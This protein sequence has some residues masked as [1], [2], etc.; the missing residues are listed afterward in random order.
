MNRRIDPA[1]G[2][3]GSLPTRRPLTTVLPLLVREARGNRLLPRDVRRAGAIRPRKGTGKLQATASGG[4]CTVCA[5]DLGS[6]QPFRGFRSTAFRVRPPRSRCSTQTHQEWLGT[7]ADTLGT[8]LVSLPELEPQADPDDGADPC[9][10]PEIDERPP[11]VSILRRLGW[12][13]GR[14]GRR[15]RGAGPIRDGSLRMIAARIEGWPRIPAIA[16]HL[17]RPAQTQKDSD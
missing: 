2:C 7:G 12:N 17:R 14:P 10:Q 3:H 4:C 13:P 16:G 11:V 15:C 6:P 9:L 1:S 8:G 5:H